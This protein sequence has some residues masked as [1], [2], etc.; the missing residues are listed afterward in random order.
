MK[1]VTVTL[2]VCFGFF[3]LSALSM[4]NRMYLLLAM[5]LALAWGLAYISVRSA[6]KS[7]KVTNSLSGTKVN[8][9]DV[10][11]MDV[12]VSHKGLLPIAPV[13]LHMR[14]TRNTPAATIHLTQ[15]GRRTQRVVHKFAADHVGAM[16][17]GVES[18]TVADVFGCLRKFT[19]PVVTPGTEAPVGTEL[20]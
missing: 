4:G 18:Y 7:V 2:G 5:I 15:L 13:A 19:V 1:S 11:S 14:G 20:G 9:G 12:G 3:L 16:L 17:P 8:R 6:E 10:V